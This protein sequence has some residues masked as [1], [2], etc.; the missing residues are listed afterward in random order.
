LL[1]QII[2]PLE[3]HVWLVYWESSVYIDNVIINI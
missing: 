3:I 1:K 2:H